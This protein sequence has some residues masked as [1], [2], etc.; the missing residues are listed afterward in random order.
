MK[1]QGGQFVPVGNVL[2]K[3]QEMQY[4]Q[5]WSSIKNYSIGDVLRFAQ[6]VRVYTEGENAAILQKKNPKLLKE[7][8]ATIEASQRLAAALG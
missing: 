4:D 6:R 3:R 2:T 7:L 8:R 1:V 5:I